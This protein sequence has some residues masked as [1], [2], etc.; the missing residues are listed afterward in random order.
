MRHALDSS[1]RALVLTCSMAL[2]FSPAT[3]QPA[4]PA[5]AA[6]PYTYVGTVHAVQPAMV[7]LDLI[8]GVG[9]AVRMV[10]MTMAPG[11]RA[12]RGGATISLADIL[13][14]AIVRAECHMT[15]AGPAVD[16]IEELVPSGSTSGRV[17]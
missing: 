15:A 6:A 14:G 16:G 17:P 1:S 12:V 7:S 8:T 10:H 2:L 3:Q 11:T 9:H 5:A 4:P 13:P